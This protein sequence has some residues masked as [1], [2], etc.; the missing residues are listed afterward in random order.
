MVSSM[1]RHT[2]YLVSWADSDWSS[3]EDIAGSL[4]TKICERMRHSVTSGEQN[5][6]MIAKQDFFRKGLAFIRM[7]VW[8]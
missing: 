8:P 6:Q 4:N 7:C 3:L 5:L 2:A 1:R